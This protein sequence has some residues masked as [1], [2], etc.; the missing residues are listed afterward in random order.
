[1]EAVSKKYFIKKLFFIILQN[2]QKHICGRVSFLIKLWP[3]LK[4]KKEDKKEKKE[5]QLYLKK[6]VAQIRC[7]PVNFAKF[8]RTPFFHR[9]LPVAVSETRSR[10]MF[11]S[12]LNTAFRTDLIPFI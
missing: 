4:K 12:F 9:R 7:F 8:L 10:T 2:S 1:M 5:T 3:L 6:T 11:S